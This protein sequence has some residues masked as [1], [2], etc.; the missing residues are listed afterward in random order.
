VDQMER[1]LPLLKIIKLINLPIISNLNNFLKKYR[2]LNIKTL[3]IEIAL[4]VDINF[5]MGLT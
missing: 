5:E 1:W 4:F 3:P 2:T